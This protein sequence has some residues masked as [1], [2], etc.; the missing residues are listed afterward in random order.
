MHPNEPA[1]R[2]EE[3]AGPAGL[4]R[5]GTPAGRLWAYA[6]LAG[7]LAGVSAWG[8]GEAAQGRF[9]STLD[10]L[11]PGE[12]VMARS[13][14]AMKTL[15]E[16]TTRKK[17]VVAYGLLG[18][19]LGLYLGLAGGLARR[20]T[21]AALRAAVAGLVLGGAAGAGL[22]ALLTPAY[23]RMLDRATEAELMNDMTRGL[24]VHAGIWSS[25]GLAAGLALGLGVG[26]RDRIA[27]A[28]LGGVFGALIASAVFELVGVAAFPTAGTGQPVSPGSSAARLMAHLLVAGFV[29]LGAVLASQH[30]RSHRSAAPV[31][32]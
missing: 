13:T 16:S 31:R 21:D 22:S 15:K 30:L 10:D 18:G 2:P 4:D 24:A 25:V 26:G 8:G 32:S 9:R 19:L 20:S 3:P 14:A 1:F 23:F 12:R 6:L 7:L 11:P 27:S 17:A 28:T 5:E 29:T